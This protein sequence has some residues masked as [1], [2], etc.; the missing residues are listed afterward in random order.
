MSNTSGARHEADSVHQSRSRS[1]PVFDWTRVAQ[2]VVF[3]EVFCRLLFVIYRFLYSNVMS[4]PL[5]LQM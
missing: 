1:P 5:D 2:S 4:V 3:H